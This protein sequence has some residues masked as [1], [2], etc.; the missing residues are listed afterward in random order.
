MNF[1]LTLEQCQFLLNAAVGFTPPD[2]LGD[3]VYGPVE[4]ALAY[5]EARALYKV[6]RSLS[7][8]LQD[9]SI[10]K[11]RLSVFG[12]V[13]EWEFDVDPA[14]N[15]V[16]GRL[17]EPNKDIPIS[18]ESESVS[19]AMWCLLLAVHPEGRDHRVGV[20]VAETIVWPIATRLG[21]VKAL[22]EAIGLNKVEKRRRWDDDPQ[23]EPEVK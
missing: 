22:R 23:P 8:S 2:K 9:V 14:G 3:V 6:L 18:L 4:K 13:E 11:R 12:P 20:S 21:K 19:G 1:R 7:P 16:S 15:P 5:D 10:A 17:R